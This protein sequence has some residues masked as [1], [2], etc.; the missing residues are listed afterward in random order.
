[1]IGKRNTRE[2]DNCGYTRSGGN[3][4]MTGRDWG[5]EAADW[6]EAKDKQYAERRE[7]ENNRFRVL[8]EQAPKLYGELTKWLALQVESFNNRSKT[9]KLECSYDAPGFTVFTSG[10]T[11]QR[12][13]NIKRESDAILYKMVK[14]T[15][16]QQYSLNTAV[17][18]EWQLVFADLQGRQETISEVG[19]R[20]LDELIDRHG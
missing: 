1:M 5:E 19:G 20:L 12:K 11:P 6:I 8:K 7:H 17:T 9:A 3:R 16:E 4:D 15:N 10:L 13:L 14:G 18:N 2:R